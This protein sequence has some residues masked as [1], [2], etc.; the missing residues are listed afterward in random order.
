MIQSLPPLRI[1]GKGV[2]MATDLESATW[3]LRRGMERR[4]KA[5]HPWVYSNELTESPKGLISG[6]PVLLQD[7]GGKFLARGYGNPKS[8]IAFRTLSRDPLNTDPTSV[9][10]VLQVLNK[11]GQ[12]RA[13]VGMKDVSHRLCFGEGDGLPGLIID[14]YV[15]RSGQVFVVQAHTAGAD[16]LEGKL[17]EIL[18]LY[19]QEQ[20]KHKDHLGMKDLQDLATWDKTSIVLRNDLS[21]RNLEGVGEQEPRILREISGHPLKAT[22]IYIQSVTGGEPLT[23]QVDLLGG[24]KT[25]FFLDQF[26]NIQLAA[27]RLKNLRTSRIRIL[28][29][30]TYVGQWGTQ[31]GR[32]YKD[33][34]LEVEVVLVDASAQALELAYQ[35]VSAQGVRCEKLKANVLRDLGQL[36]DQSFDLVI[37]DPPAL[38]KGR[39]DIPTGTHAYLQLA[40]QVFR[41]LKKDGGVVCCSCSAL[42]EEESFMHMLSKG[43][44]KNGVSVRWVGRGSQS[45][46]HPMLIEFPEG[47]YLKGWIGIV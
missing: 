10:S 14:R 41:L 12:L 43:A 45:P 23:F 13:A 46:D 24:Q 30:C 35:N 36:P 17:L 39:K 27:V 40:T 34:G 44:L 33:L 25:G 29:L 5:G 42:L 4:F 20:Q 16:Q 7:A 26:A 1:S 6:S 15:T 31:L 2:F 11:A 18:E 3:R 47:R 22:E 32:V 21:V 19:V 8:L 38:I 28:D 9:A 37:S